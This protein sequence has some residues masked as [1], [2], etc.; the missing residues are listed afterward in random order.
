ML[1]KNWERSILITGTSS[2]IGRECALYLAKL[3]YRVFA[4]V[5][6]EADAAAIK[7]RSFFPPYSRHFGCD[8][9]RFYC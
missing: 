1:D 8:Q 5:R 9:S 4:G 7:K 2:G 3:G 6:N